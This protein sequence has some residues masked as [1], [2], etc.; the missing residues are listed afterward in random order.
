MRLELVRL[1][2]E[3]AAVH[4]EI[5]GRQASLRGALADLAAQPVGKRLPEQQEFMQ[6]SAIEEAQLD[7]L[8]E[9]L[10]TLQ[11]RRLEK[12]AAFSRIRS[13][14]ETLE[15]LREKAVLKHTMAMRK[16]DRKELDENSRLT[17]AREII[18]RRVGM[19]E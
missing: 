3:I 18:E 6:R 1:S 11:D 5:F 2:Q 12:T 13:A 7:R 8:R 14:R 9:A 4:R 10:K 15:K 16:R 19:A 17:F